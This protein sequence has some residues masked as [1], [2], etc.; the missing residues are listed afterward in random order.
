MI[1][2]ATNRL[3]HENEFLACAKLSFLNKVECFPPFAER[4]WVEPSFAK[5]SDG[6][7]ITCRLDKKD[8]ETKST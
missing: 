5:A 6:R 1:E 3:A 7:P 8:P 2:S 4:T